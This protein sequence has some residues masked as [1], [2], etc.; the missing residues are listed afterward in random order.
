MNG[1]KLGIT[2]NKSGIAGGELGISVINQVRFS[3]T[4]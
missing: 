4:L 2:G 1:G 3:A